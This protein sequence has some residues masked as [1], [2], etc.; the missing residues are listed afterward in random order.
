MFHNW[1]IQILGLKSYS[2]KVNQTFKI[3]ILLQDENSSIL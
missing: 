2:Y 1:I 3:K